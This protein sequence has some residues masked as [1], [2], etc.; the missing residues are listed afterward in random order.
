MARYGRARLGTGTS[1]GGR[2]RFRWIGAATTAALVVS[3]A[4]IPAGAATD[5][6]PSA[7][8]EQPADEAMRAAAEARASG[9]PVELVST[10]TATTTTYVNPDGTETVEI[11]QEPTRVKQDG[12]YVDIDTSLSKE[13]GVLVPAASP[14]DVEISDG[15]GTGE[16]LATVSKGTKSLSLD[17][18]A[19]LPAAH[20]DGAEAN[21]D[22]GATRDVNVT[23][24]AD[25]FTI[26]ILLD[27]A[28]TAAP[29]YRL[30]ITAKGVQMEPDSVGGYAAEDAAGMVRFR[31]AP[32]K[33]WDANPATMIEGNQMDKVAVD[34][35]LV[36]TAA[37]GQVLEL[38][39]DF[40]WLSDPSRVGPITIDPDVYVDNVGVQDT[41]VK[42][43]LPGTNYSAD[44][45]ASIGW[46]GTASRVTRK[47][48]L[49]LVTGG[50]EGSGVGRGLS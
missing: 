20:V 15:L 24:T 21:F 11:T 12:E 46:T 48:A 31:V 35:R 10:Q 2:R 36:T 47:V 9:E 13:E 18:P 43:A 19:D 4:Q 6:T 8:S 14:A 30:P 23:A 50:L 22:A 27:Q 41:Y 5:P 29:V 42:Q 49:M 38:R 26:H 1:E 34:S 39:P 40:A 33:M 25:G 3:L 16:P 17:W 45:D 32:L 28:P 44:E 37:G 7:S